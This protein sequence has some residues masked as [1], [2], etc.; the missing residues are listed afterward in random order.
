MI[1]W[2]ALLL[3]PRV[4]ES[5]GLL[6]AQ[7]APLLGL[8]SL[9]LVHREVLVDRKSRYVTLVHRRLWLFRKTRVIPFKHIHRIDYDYEA[10]TTSFGR[11]LDPSIIERDEIDSFHVALIL[12]PRTDV[13]DSH[14]HLYEERV[15]LFGFH[16]EGDGVEE[17]RSRHFVERIRALTGVGFGNELQALPDEHGLTWAC[18]GC[19][20]SGPPRAGKC[21][22]CGGEL[23]PS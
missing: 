3:S 23:A 17:V 20:R 14:A 13:P 2:S 11:N 22:Y 9:G 10:T 5:D 4:T 7:T 12:R 8:L 19:G 1:G 18:R 15:Q 16:G 6:R 21:Y